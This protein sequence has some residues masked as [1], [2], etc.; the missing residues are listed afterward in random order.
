MPWY[1]QLSFALVAIPC[2][3]VPARAE[4]E[5]E[6]HWDIPVPSAIPGGISYPVDVAGDAGDRVYVLCAV[7]T[8]DR[9][10]TVFEGDGTIVSQ[11]TTPRG[12]ET[13]LAVTSEGEIVLLDEASATL[14]FFGATGEPHGSFSTAPT[15]EPEDVAAVPWGGVVVCGDRVTHFDRQG[16]V[17]D[18]WETWLLREPRQ[19]A[20]PVTDYCPTRSVAAHPEGYFLVP[21]WYGVVRLWPGEPAEV[22]GPDD[23]YYGGWWQSTEPAE[24]AIGAHGGFCTRSLG[25]SYLVLR[26]PRGFVMEPYGP[27]EPIRIAVDG[28]GRL[29]DLR[30]FTR[31]WHRGASVARLRP[32]G[33]VYVG[34]SVY[35]SDLPSIRVDGVSVPASGHFEWEPGSV[36][37]LEANHVPTQPGERWS[38]HGWDPERAG[39]FELVVPEIAIGLHADF[40]YEYEVT[41]EVEGGGTATPGSHWVPRWT[42]VDFAAMP[43]PGWRFAHWTGSDEL[44]GA[45]D[46]REA[47]FT[48]V[49]EHGVRYTAHFVRDGLTFTLSASD[50]DPFATESQPTHGLRDLHLWAGCLDRGLSAFEAGVEGSIQVLGFEPADGMLSLGPPDAPM[51]ALGG[52]PVGESVRLG[53]F[54][55]WDDGGTLAFTDSPNGMMVAVDCPGELQSW[56]FEWIGFSSAGASPRSADPHCPGDRVP[57]AQRPGLAED[58]AESPRLTLARNPFRGELPIGLDLAG[59]PSGE[60]RVFD[61]LGRQVRTLPLASGVM[62]A[63]WDARDEA[64]APVRAGVYFVRLTTAGESRTSKVV[65]LGP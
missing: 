3:V 49:I 25:G 22:F 42:R 63:R 41:V 11:W 38:F 30:E 20:D 28:R 45:P 13:D 6:A 40:R 53:K 61:V 35:G 54:T 47:E 26:G 32:S 23:Y 65:Y 57:A 29:V 59:A 21:L 51:I 55:V 19:G 27:G 33:S 12:T 62:A 64:G 1:R 15:L 24:L 52:C 7:S 8:P 9:F 18:S 2:L 5:L 34:T 16:Q 31:E 58:H 14:S 36:H 37:H 39:A 10:V 17:I 48:R 43:D 60:L 50:T 46:V 56:P 44:P 4:L